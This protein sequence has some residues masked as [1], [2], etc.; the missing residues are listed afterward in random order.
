MIF[1]LITKCYLRDRKGAE[2]SINDS[3]Q[4]LNIDHVDLLIFRHVQE[5]YE[6]EQ[7]FSN[8]GAME[9]FEKAKEDGKIRFI[10]ISRHGIPDVLIKALKQYHFDV[11]MTGFNFFNRFNFRMLKMF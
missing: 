10:G 1:F 9:A 2:K 7:I 8:N 3:L 5:E 6:L 4:R 11:L